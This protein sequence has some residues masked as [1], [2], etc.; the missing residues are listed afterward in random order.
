MRQSCLTQAWV[1]LSLIAGAFV[2]GSFFE[3]ITVVENGITFDIDWFGYGDLNPFRVSFTLDDVLSSYW[4]SDTGRIVSLIA[5]SNKYV[6]TTGSTKA[7]GGALLMSPDSD[8]DGSRMLVSMNEETPSEHKGFHHRRLTFAC[9]DCVELVETLCSISLADVCF[10]RNKFLELFSDEGQDSLVTMCDVFGEVCERGAAEICEEFCIGGELSRPTYT[11]G[12]ENL[13][14]KAFL[15]DG[16]PQLS[17]H[18]TFTR[19]FGSYL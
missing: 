14:T 7:G 9:A 17:L 1:L 13:S 15:I 6:F 11:L 2:T 5:G 4:F 12:V 10:V 19:I 16:A 8:K 18:N 3:T